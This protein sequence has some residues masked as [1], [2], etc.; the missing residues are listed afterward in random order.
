MPPKKK[1]SVSCTHCDR[2]YPLEETRFGSV[3]EA[4]GQEFMC[5]TCVLESRLDRLEEEKLQ[6]RAQVEEL[7]EQLK[8][9]R[10]QREGLE[11]ASAG[12]KQRC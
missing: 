12:G 1:P 10:G 7:V 3:E 6:L 5:R 9:E 11:E 2:E 8:I 4:E